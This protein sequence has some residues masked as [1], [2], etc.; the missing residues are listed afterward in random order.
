VEP[1]CAIALSEAE[2]KINSRRL[3]AY[4]KLVREIDSGRKF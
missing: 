1:G 4:R 2:G 3:D